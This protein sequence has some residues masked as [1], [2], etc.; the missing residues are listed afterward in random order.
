MK[1]LAGILAVVICGFAVIAADT[2]IFST[3]YPITGTVTVPVTDATR[4]YYMTSVLLHFNAPVSNTFSVAYVRG[5]VTNTLLSYTHTAMDQLVWFIPAR[6][7]IKGGD[8]LIFKNTTA[9]AGTVTVN[10]EF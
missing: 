7:Y 6:V 2:Y 9:T 1:M 8:T 3:P 5:A 10:A 4:P